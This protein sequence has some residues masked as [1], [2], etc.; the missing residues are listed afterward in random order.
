MNKTGGRA[1][2]KG[3]NA[4]SWAALSLF[5]Q[6]VRR[7]DLHHIAFEQDKL[8]DFDLVFSSGKK[9]ICESKTE[10][11]THSVLK[12]ILKKLV[13]ND[14][15]G[16]EDEILIIC[17]DLSSELISDVEN[18]KYF[19]NIKV[20]LKKKGF[21]DKQFDLFSRIKFWKVDKTT[22]Q[23]I[24][25]SLLAEILN[26]WVPENTFNEIVSDLILE[27]VYRGSENGEV[28]TRKNFYKTIEERKRQIQKDAGYQN[29][30]NEKLAQIDRVLN[31]INKP[32]RQSW[33]NDQISLLTTTPDLYYLTI[34]KL[35]SLPHLKLSQWKNLWKAATKGVF[36]SHV[37]NIFGKNL[38]DPENRKFMIDFLPTIAKNLLSFYRQEFFVV[39]IKDICTKILDQTRIY[40]DK[41]FNILKNLL[42]LSSKEVFY[43]EKNIDRSEWELEEVTNAFKKIYEIADEEVKTKII[44]FI[45]EFFDLVEDDGE[46]WHFTPKAIFE[47]IKLYVEVD[48]E[49]RVL[50]LSKE[51]SKQYEKF[52][53]S[54]RRKSSFKGWELMGFTN[55]DRHFISY[56]LQPI[57]SQYY[58]NNPSKAWRFITEKLISRKESLVSAEKPDYLNRAAIPVI[59]AA[60]QNPQY[61]AEAFGIIKDFVEMKKGIPHKTGSVYRKVSE[62]SLSD[63]QK[64]K[65]IKLQLDYKPYRN[66]PLNKYV[67]NTVSELANK[68]HSEALMTIEGWAT[69][70]EFN[71]YRGVLEG[72][73]TSKVPGLVANPKTKNQG[74][75]ILKQFLNSDFF[76]NKQGSWDVWETAKVLTLLLTVDFEEGRSIIQEIWSNN[77]LTKNQQ[78]VI[79]SS[80][81]DIDK[82]DALGA[83]AYD[84]I[85]S[86]WLDD[87]KD[88]IKLL[89]N[90]IPDIQS[91][92]SL[93]QFGEK[94][95]KSGKYDSA[96]RIAKIFINDTDPGLE[97]EADDK[98]G[99]FNYHEQVKRGK[100][101]NSITTVRASVAWLL[102]SVSVLN[103]RNYIPEI[104]PLVKKLTK[105]PNFYV[106]AYSCIPLEQ[107]ASIRHT[108]LPFDRKTRFLDIK[109]AD[110]IEAIAY[111][112]LRNKENW[113]LEQVMMGIL[114]TFSNI[115][116][117]TTEE[118]KEILDIFL[119]T[120]N[121]K[122]IE[123]AR[124]LFIFFAEFRKKA[125]DNKK[126]V[127]VY[128]K[129]R[130][131]ELE[132]FDEKYFKELLIKI[133]TE[134]PSDVRGGYAWAFWH[135][136]KEPGADLEESFKISYKYLTILATKYDHEV[137]TDI[138]YFL[139]EFYEKEFEKCFELWKKCLLVER[140]Y[141]QRKITKDNLYEMHWWPFHHNGQMVV[142]ISNK[143]GEGAFLK[144]VEYLLGYPEGVIVA[145]DLILI[146]DRLE[147]LPVT[148]LSK[149]IFKKIAVHNPEYFERMKDWLTK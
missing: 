25:E 118:A 3:I 79:T 111:G 53:K 47:I 62:S 127:N 27:K 41:V 45:F 134:Y 71:K 98:E 83:R 52:Y 48:V 130:I 132:K 140:P 128:S 123:E 37:F 78:V 9:I 68:G 57:L 60:Y 84:E 63:D 21:D 90:K 24:V 75:A 136:P 82:N 51:L 67:E 96:V 29:K 4:Q 56:V 149:S 26:V 34:Q 65:L 49:T 81:N 64:W 28:L 116:T 18:L 137:M 59:F 147:T 40:D 106:R 146:V 73:I 86:I 23:L 126:L 145:D 105:D 87:C 112:M 94:L 5:L 54:S 117:V 148:K 103:G 110:K 108:V 6:Y 141:L 138:Y 143:K 12:D 113:G 20:G 133:L 16:K 95:A 42:E 1:T 107:L 80:I 114:R 99:K 131:K 139:E 91:R 104:I 93:V 46:F 11:V 8:K 100:D 88:D 31:A 15:V 102:Q 69:N 85:V 7:S 76:I 120:G 55:T 122:I 77:S 135:L 142:E 32:T 89:I 61:K 50:A 125:I 35:E 14:K 30:Q 39:D 121:N 124:V 38:D 22:N 58:S 13:N 19:E 101:V 33:C 36:S 10:K 97:N 43:A 144:W 72:N 92:I 2:Y 129:D 119:K 66:L 17:Q 109:I 74:I 44:N 70:P 115:R